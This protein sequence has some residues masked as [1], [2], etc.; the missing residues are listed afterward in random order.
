MTSSE[1]KVARK[2]LRIPDLPHMNTDPDNVEA[3]GTPLPRPVDAEFARLLLNAAIPIGLR[4]QLDRAE[5]IC[6]SLTVPGISWCEPMGKA[7][8]A[9]W[10]GSHRVVRDGSKHYDH[11]PA[12]GNDEVADYLRKGEPVIGVSHAPTRYQPST[13]LSA[14]DAHLTIKPP[15]GLLLRKLIQSCVIGRAPRELPDGLASGLDFHEILSAFRRGA[16]VAKVLENLE[17]ATASKSRISPDDDTPALDKIAGYVEAK[18]WG[19]GLADGLAAWRRGEVAWR[20]LSS[21]AVLHGPPGAGK[22]LFAKSLAKTLGVPIVVTSPGDWFATTSGYIDSVIKAMQDAFDAARALAPAVLFIDE[23]EG[24]PDRRALS[25]RGRDWWTPIIN[26]ALTLFDGAATSREGIILLG[27]TNYRDRLDPALIRPGRFDRLILVPPPDVD[28]LAGILR[29]HLGADLPDV[30]LRL[31][32]R[33]RTGATGAEAAQWVRDAKARARAL[34]R[35]ARFDDLLSEALPPETRPQS[36]LL[37]VARHEAAHACAALAL[38]IQRLESVTLCE[39]GS[40]GVARFTTRADIPMSRANIEANCIVTLAGRAADELFGEADA[41]AGGGPTSDLRRATRHLALTHASFGLGER[42]LS[43]DPDEAVAR[44][45]LDPVL[46]AAIE[47]DLQRLYARAR[48]LVREYRSDIERLAAAL[49]AR[50]YISGDE[51]RALLKPVPD[52]DPAQPTKSG[53]RP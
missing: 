41:G 45:P 50:R 43:L 17:R 32:A 29:H 1:K 21:A 13:L 12:K 47:A 7:V 8:Q 28:G 15:N 27:A 49:V 52:F 22:T 18:Q 25:D 48:L 36:E 44:I 37:S 34:G 42:L 6:L 9:R 38:G 5:P 35:D 33:Q 20:A 3:F 26:F 51:V 46:A 11:F 24:L 2:R 19:L 14:A 53:R 10:P 23:L 30:D 16:G 4:R 40:A 39:P 31:I